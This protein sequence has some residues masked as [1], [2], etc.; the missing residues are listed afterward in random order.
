MG[1]RFNS[2]GRKLVYAEGSVSLAMLE[3]LSQAG[4]RSRLP[5]YVCIPISFDGS[6]VQSADS[7]D[8]PSQWDARPHVTASQ[9]FGDQW[10]ADGRSLVLRVPSVVNPLEHNYL[11]NPGHEDFAKLEIGPPSPAPFDSRLLRP[12]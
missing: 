9:N 10:I 7:D 2:K 1:A 3:I 5:D 6:V 12:T 4:D 8:L 11:I